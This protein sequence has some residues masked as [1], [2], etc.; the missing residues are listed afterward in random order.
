MENPTLQ[1]SHMGHGESQNIQNYVNN[2]LK[3]GRWY[4]KFDKK[5]SN[6][7]QEETK[8]KE[9]F[10]WKICRGLVDKLIGTYTLKVFSSSIL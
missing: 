1:N 10:N 8:D 7:K 6:E 4:L 9:G 5:M 2:L 3:D